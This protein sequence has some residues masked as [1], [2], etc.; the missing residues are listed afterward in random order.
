MYYSTQGKPVMSFLTI[1][2]NQE[3]LNGSVEI[4]NSPFNSLIF[5][6]PAQPKRG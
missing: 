5:V 6:F 1:H 2:P 3:N 4:D